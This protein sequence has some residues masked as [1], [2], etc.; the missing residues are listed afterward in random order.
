M[1]TYLLGLGGIDINNIWFLVLTLFKVVDVL[2]QPPDSKSFKC[3]HLQMQTWGKK[4]PLKANLLIEYVFIK[5]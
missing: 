5:S 4:I 3:V 2:T 1:N